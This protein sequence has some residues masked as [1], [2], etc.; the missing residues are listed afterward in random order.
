MSPLENNAPERAVAAADEVDLF[1]LLDDL[2]DKWYWALGAFLITLVLAVVYA[3]VATPVYQTEAII[4]D[5]PP[6]KLL[7]FNQPALRSTLSL[8][9]S[10]QDKAVSG[11]DDKSVMLTDEAV[12]QLDPETAFSSARSVIRS[13]STRKAFYSE[14]LKENAP[15][16]MALIFSADLTEEQNLAYFLQRFSFTDPGKNDGAD[17]YL[18]IR[19]ELESS[20]Q[21]ARDVLNKYVD[22]ALALNK[23]RVHGEFDQKVNAE[24]DLTR[25]WAQNFRTE[26]E[27]D[28]ARRI[29]TLEEAA[30]IAKS[31]GQTRPF[32]NSNDI[33]VSSEPP[34]YM[35]GETALRREAELLKS[36]SGKT[37]EDV[38]VAGLSAINNYIAALEGVSVD[39]SGVDLVEID[40]AALL[41]LK[42]V[43]PRKAL[44]VAAGGVGGLVLGVLA[45]LLAA[46][47]SRHR[48][49]SERA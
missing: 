20:S 38:F 12:F 22:F 10:V 39:W 36:R 45:A 1:D 47:S 29:A 2:Q 13:A 24:L 49:R 28:K 34:L 23:K 46:A 5:V 37:S 48:R 32:Y 7:A 8:T 15:E 4:T 30:D 17:T 16:L 41:P 19:F 26:Y 44:I 31:I 35:M 40:Q 11:N 21:L 18:S 14:L 9:G 3:Y 25:T 27:A 43:K 42:P 33:V 6:S